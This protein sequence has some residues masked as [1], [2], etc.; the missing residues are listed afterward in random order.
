VRKTVTVVFADV[1]GSTSLGERLDPEALRY[2]MSRWFEEARA[3]LERH[4]EAVGAVE[5]AVL[6]YERKGNAVS[7]AKARLSSL[8]PV[9]VSRLHADTD[10]DGFCLQVALDRL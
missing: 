9:R 1:T 5:E 4:G 7:A 3:S 8:Q 10:E 6:L 2:V